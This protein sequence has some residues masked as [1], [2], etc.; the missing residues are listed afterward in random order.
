MYEPWLA[1]QLRNSRAFSGA[2]VFALPLTPLVVSSVILCVLLMA[3]ALYTLWAE[4]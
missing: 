2:V 1:A 4:K 3:G